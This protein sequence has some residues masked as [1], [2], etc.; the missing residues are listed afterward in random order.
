[1]ASPSKKQRL[2]SFVTEFTEELDTELK[3][4]CYD[5]S[6]KNG[7]PAIKAVEK[8]RKVKAMEGKVITL[9]KL[10]ES[11]NAKL[12][13]ENFE[14]KKEIENLQKKIKDLEEDDFYLSFDETKGPSHV[15]TVASPEA[16]QGSTLSSPGLSQG[17]TV[18]SPVSTQVPPS[19]SPKDI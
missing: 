4:V 19:G 8:I 2:D 15:A 1:M 9:A 11:E 16:S 18:S 13:K 7:G 17:S 6:T 3:A 5:I 12:V 14:M 10:N